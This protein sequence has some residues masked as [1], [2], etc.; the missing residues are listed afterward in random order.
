MAERDDHRP[1]LPGFVE[2][3]NEMRRGRIDDVLQ[4]NFDQLSQSKSHRGVFVV[5]QQR[6]ICLQQMEMRVHGLLLVEIRLAQAL[7][8]GQVQLRS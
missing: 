2:E 5:A 3:K 7:V 8:R 4:K 6:G 1:W